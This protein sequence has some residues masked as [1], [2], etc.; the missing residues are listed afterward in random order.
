MKN[1]F[2]P[3]FIKTMRSIRKRWSQK[4]GVKRVRRKKRSG[5]KSVKK[6]AWNGWG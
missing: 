5:K 2:R 1:G 6:L 4:S 3:R